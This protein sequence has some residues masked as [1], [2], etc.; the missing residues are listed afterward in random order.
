[1]RRI[2]HTKS[3]LLLDLWKGA[4][5]SRLCAS[6]GSL[7]SVGVS[8]LTS[9]HTAG[10]A[11]PPYCAMQG[12]LLNKSAF[13]GVS[14]PLR[15]R[16]AVQAFT[17]LE[18]L[19]VIAIICILMALVIPAVGSIGRANNLT[20]ATQNF[21]AQI[22]RARQEA[23]TRNR[24]VEF[25]LLSA[26][27]EA[28]EPAAYRA[29]RYIICDEVGLSSGSSAFTNKTMWFP[30]GVVINTNSSDLAQTLETNSVTL[31]GNISATGVRFR[32]RPNGLI[33]TNSNGALSSAT[34]LQWTLTAENGGTNNFSTIQ[35][36]TRTG[37]TRLF[38]P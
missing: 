20:V 2:H 15:E 34:N 16:R 24:S 17:L 6:V 32:I 9:L 11:M 4:Q 19:T 27:R 21:I 14:A 22:N 12:A 13:P 28:G 1:M 35:I 5:A 23:L 30:Q 38:R 25:Q 29:M 26:Q 37:I 7:I 3:S 33:S 31:S 8:K 36:D 10:T 18:L